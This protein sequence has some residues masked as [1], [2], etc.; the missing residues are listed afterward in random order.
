M[1]ETVEVEGKEY[2]LDKSN[3]KSCP[4]RFVRLGLNVECI[5]CGLGYF[6]PENQFPLEEA[7]KKFAVEQQ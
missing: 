4:H 5:K 2:T 6:D 1:S 7:N 3:I